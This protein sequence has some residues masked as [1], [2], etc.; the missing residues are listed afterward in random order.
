MPSSSRA[1]LACVLSH[2]ERFDAPV[3]PIAKNGKTPLTPHGFKD[4]TR[5]PKRIREWARKFPGCNWAMATGRSSGL[6]VL[7]VDNKPEQDRR[8]EVALHALLPSPNALPPTVVVETPSGGRHY[9][10]R[11]TSAI[12]NSNDRL[13][14]GLDVRGEGGYVLIPPSSI[15]GR[16]YRFIEGAE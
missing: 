16:P 10:F 1:D 3:F 11:T 6:V 13:G 2:V 4:A 5:D 7:D 14:S 12:P 15:D 8:G 9:Y